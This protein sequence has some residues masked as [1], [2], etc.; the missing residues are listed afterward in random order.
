MKLVRPFAFLALVLVA[1]PA[2]S[3]ERSS[4]PAAPLPLQ[5]YIAAFAGAADIGSDITPTFAGEFGESV[6]RNAQAYATFTY[7][8]NVMTDKMRDNLVAAGNYVQQVTGVSRTFTGRDRGL[9]LTFGGKYVVGTTVRPY[10]GAGGGW[11]H[12]K[13]MISESSLGD[14]SAA[15]ASQA[16]LG[17]GVITAGFTE[18]TKPLA[19]AVA[20]IGFVT[21]NTYIDVGYRYR[22]AFH[23][24]TTLELSQVVFGIGAKW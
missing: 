20:G 18:E 14:V 12:I 24:A 19:E 1:S 7:F 2:M 3:Q 4:S 13:R 17:D 10:V 23:S 8:D 16:G 21:H 22:R 15:F 11:L 9:G 6:T 5:R